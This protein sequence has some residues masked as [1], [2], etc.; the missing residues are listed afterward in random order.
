MLI[1]TPNVRG[2][3]FD[4]DFFALIYFRTLFYVP[5]LKPYEVVGLQPGSNG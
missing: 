2:A 4:V 1:T 3:R 5:V